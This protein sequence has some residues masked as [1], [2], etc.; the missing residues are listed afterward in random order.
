MKGDAGQ[1][2]GPMSRCSVAADHLFNRD[3]AAPTKTQTQKIATSSHHKFTVPAKP[4]RLSAL[5]CSTV[6]MPATV[7]DL[8]C[9]LYCLGARL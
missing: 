3:A 5:S 2:C 6:G 7:P 4:F 9:Q 1:I 8:A